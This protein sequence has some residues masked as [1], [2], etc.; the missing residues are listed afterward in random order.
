MRKKGTKT[1]H[2]IDDVSVG[3]SSIIMEESSNFG[4]GFEGISDCHRY[5]LSETAFLTNSSVN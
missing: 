1:K 2:H 3:K 5:T 4:D